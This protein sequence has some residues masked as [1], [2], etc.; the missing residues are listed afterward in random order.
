MG[1]NRCFPLVVLLAIAAASACTTPPY[2]GNLYGSARNTLDWSPQGYI[3]FSHGRAAWPPDE[4]TSLD[5]PRSIYAV[6][7]DGS[8]M[9][10]IELN[11]RVDPWD[12]SVSPRLSPDGS[13]VAYTK[14]KQGRCLGIGGHNWEVYVANIDGSNKRR[15]TNRGGYS[16]SWS[17]DGRRILLSSVCTDNLDFSSVCIMN[18][19]GS[20]AR[21]LPWKGFHGIGTAWSPDGLR[22]ALFGSRDGRRMLYVA[23]ADGSELDEVAVVEFSQK[24]TPPS[25]SPDGN[26]FVFA[27][28]CGST[29]CYNRDD[30]AIFVSSFDGGSVWKLANIPPGKANITTQAIWSPNGVEILLNDGYAGGNVRLVSRDGSLLTSW[31]IL[32]GPDHPGTLDQ[33]WGDIAAAWSPDG[34]KIAFH[35]GE[36]TVWTLNRDGTGL[37]VLVVKGELA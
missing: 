17:P 13:K 16:P 4:N 1:M 23:T 28:V 21:V 26:H 33:P 37:R 18:E 6:K 15:L 29:Q 5:A 27:D 3:V 7:D 19:D 22:I 32:G 31:P 36:G 11:T 30:M 2:Q 14:F 20:D 8:H 9:E 35:D 10:I 34:L 25:W 24:L 12:S